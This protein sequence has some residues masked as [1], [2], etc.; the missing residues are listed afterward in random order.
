LNG[1]IHKGIFP[2]IRPLPATPN[3]P[4]Q[5]DNPTLRPQTAHSLLIARI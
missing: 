2:Y 5:Q 1:P 4:F 3:F